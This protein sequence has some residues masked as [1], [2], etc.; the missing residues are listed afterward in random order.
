MIDGNDDSIIDVAIGDAP[1]TRSVYK[2]HH[3]RLCAELNES[4][5]FR[6]I[7]SYISCSTAPQRNDRFATSTAHVDISS[8]YTPEIQPCFAESGYLEEEL[9]EHFSRGASWLGIRSSE[10]LVSVCLVFPNHSDI[11]EIGG[12]YT[13]PQYRRCGFG[14]AV[15]RAALRFLH[16]KDLVPRYQF[17]EDNQPSRALAESIGLVERLTV[18]HYTTRS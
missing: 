2:L 16:Q 6:R 4:S 13:K 7:T 5:Q 11:W 8:T 3:H 10:E 9:K 14:S 15:T 1:R 17:R 18:V 12:V